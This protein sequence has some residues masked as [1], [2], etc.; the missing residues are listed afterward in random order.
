MWS[1]EKD[2]EKL[3]IVAASKAISEMKRCNSTMLLSE[4]DYTESQTIE[5]SIHFIEQCREKI[6]VAIDEVIAEVKAHR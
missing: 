1:F 3:S 5:K 4:E 6:N 2:S